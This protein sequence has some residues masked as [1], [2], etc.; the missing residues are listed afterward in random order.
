LDST[1]ISD[2]QCLIL[3]VQMPG[4]TGLDL[5]ELLLSQ[6]HKIAVIMVTAY[7]EI[8]TRKRAL[9]AGASEFLVKPLDE[10]RLVLSLLK[11][12]GPAH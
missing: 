1:D 10:A 9:D 12:V 4:L 8:R 2:T 3:D 11:A 7:P 6:G 5:Q